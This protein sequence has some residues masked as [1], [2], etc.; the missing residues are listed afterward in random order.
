M[1]DLVEAAFRT[2][3]D[4]EARGHLGALQEADVAALSP[5]MELIQRGIEA[6]VLDDEAADSR[7]EELL[8]SPAS[9]RWLFEACRIR[10][11]Y[12]ESLRR[13]KIAQRAQQHLLEA[14]GGFAAMGAQPWLVRTQQELR[15]NGFR[16]EHG[17]PASAPLTAQE[18]E[19]AHLAASGMTNRQI[20]E[21]LY[22]SHRTVG[23]HLYRIFPKLGVSS[24]AALRDALSADPRLDPSISR[25]PPHTH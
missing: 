6:L 7:L 21:R 15:A 17:Q 8:T 1:F 11:A 9:D 16:S 2:G 10:L 3:R 14:R 24:R 13:R 23:A 18:L 20:A 4:E 12:A 22:L 25:K 5:R 19:V